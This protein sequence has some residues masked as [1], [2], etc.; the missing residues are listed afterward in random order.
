MEITLSYNPK[1]K[2][3]RLSG[4]IFDEIREHFS[5]AIDGIHFIKKVNKF[6]KSREYAIT[7]TGKFDIGLTYEILK[8][9]K[10]TKY[11]GK[12]S[13]S[14]ELKRVLMPDFNIDTDFSNLSMSLRDYQLDVINNLKKNGRGI[15]KLA[16]GGGKTLLIC[17]LLQGFIRK[18]KG[19]KCLVIV[20]S[21]DLVEQTFKDFTD[22]NPDFTYS[23]WSGTNELDIS[24]DVIIANS[25]ILLNRYEENKW[26]EV[27]DMVICD[28]CHKLKKSN[29]LTAFLGKIKTHHK[30]GFTG[31]LPETKMDYWSILGDFG[32]VIFEL[33][34][35]ELRESGYLANV[36]T[37]VLCI[38]YKS[39]PFMKYKAELNYIY[40]NSYRANLITKI[41]EK[42]NKNVLI[43]VNHIRYGEKLLNSIQKTG[44]D[45]YFIQ[46]KVEV[47]A[48][49]ELIEL[50]EKRDGIICIAISNIFSTGINLK[51]LHMLI[52][53]NAGKSF[54]RTVQ[55]VGRGLRLHHNKDKL[56]IFDIS[57]NLTYSSEHMLKRLEI[58][59]KEKI[60]YSIVEINE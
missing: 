29:E 54:I 32:R 7:P 45:V 36:T 26:L 28:E 1:H 49:R 39:A 6:A 55:S 43:L 38:N 48:R 2:Q 34:S 41:V 22:Y 30:F 4:D 58:Y 42:Y 3:A 25:S 9:I 46:G 57:D 44:K 10:Q 40:E 16:T 12:I 18:H 51:N 53:A 37:K 5:V 47:E 11:T 24:T 33:S 27:V 17:S 8:Y 21:V 56:I 13:I 60:N 50:M 35:S 20:P 14:P 31:T 52:F 15:V 19:S 23:K 59:N